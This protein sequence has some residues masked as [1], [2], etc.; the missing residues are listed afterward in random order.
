MKLR[1]IS[2]LKKIYIDIRGNLG[3]NSKFSPG[4][5]PGLE[6][7]CLQ[8]RSSTTCNIHTIYSTNDVYYSEFHH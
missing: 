2:Q 8:V 3:G 6:L 1:Q 5:S 4:H 7:T